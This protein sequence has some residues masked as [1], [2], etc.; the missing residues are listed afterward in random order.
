MPRLRLYDNP[1]APRFKTWRDLGRRLRAW[2]RWILKAL[3]SAGWPAP[4]S[5]LASAAALRQGALLSESISV[6]AA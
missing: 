6:R 5:P 3:Y 2:L 1:A 4:P